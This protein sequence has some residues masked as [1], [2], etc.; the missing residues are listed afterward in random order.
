MDHYFSVTRSTKETFAI[1]PNVLTYVPTFSKKNSRHVSSER[2]VENRGR[3]G[4]EVRPWPQPVALA[5]RGWALHPRCAA[6]ALG[7]RPTL[8]RP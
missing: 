1:K 2:E 7:G 6:P 4:D 3:D 8:A 5:L